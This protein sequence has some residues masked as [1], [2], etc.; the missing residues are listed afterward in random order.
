MTQ[1]S[2]LKHKIVGD[3]IHLWLE[4]R[5]ESGVRKQY[6]KRSEPGEFKEKAETKY[7]YLTET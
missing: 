6:L 5:A 1:P 7:M 3:T 2:R 4:M